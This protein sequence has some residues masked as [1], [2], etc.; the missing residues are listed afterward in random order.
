MA[1]IR[2]LERW[3]KEH[4]VQANLCFVGICI[5]MFEIA[6]FLEFIGK[7]LDHLKGVGG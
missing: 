4:P 5:L 1:D 7:Y 2:N 3:M 6:V